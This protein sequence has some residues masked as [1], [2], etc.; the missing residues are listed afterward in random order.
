[1]PT[2]RGDDGGVIASVIGV[3]KCETQRVIR[4]DGPHLDIT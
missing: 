2:K 4:F 3:D 1:M